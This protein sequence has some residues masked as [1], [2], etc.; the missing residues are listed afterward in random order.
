MLID[1]NNSD[2][3]VACLG[4]RTRAECLRDAENSRMTIQDWVA[5]CIRESLDQGLVVVVDGETLSA[6][7]A[8]SALFADLCRQLGVDCG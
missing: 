7:D 8:Q 4:S 2:F 3:F 6:R 1:D 5:E